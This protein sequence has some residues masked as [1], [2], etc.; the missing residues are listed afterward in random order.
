M[1]KTIKQVKP[2]KKMNLHE[3]RSLERKSSHKCKN[4]GNIFTGWTSDNFKND[5]LT[6]FC[7]KC[8]SE[9]HYSYWGY[10]S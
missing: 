7:P 10:G 5:Y 2:K 4:C 6:C 9:N 1:C 3:R 8:K